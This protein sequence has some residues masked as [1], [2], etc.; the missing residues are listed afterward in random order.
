M[1]GIVHYELFERKLTVTAE[2]Y[3]KRLRRLEEAKSPGS[4]TWSDSSA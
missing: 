4:T 3:Y 2:R 1:E